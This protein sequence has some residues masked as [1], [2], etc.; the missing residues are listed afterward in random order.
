[1]DAGKSS[2]AYAAPQAPVAFGAAARSG[3]GRAR[4]G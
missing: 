2:A 1:M 3:L 4:I